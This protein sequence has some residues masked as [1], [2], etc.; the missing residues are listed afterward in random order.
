MNLLLRIAALCLAISAAAQPFWIRTGPEYL[1]TAMDSGTPVQLTLYAAPGWSIDQKIYCTGAQP[2]VA[3]NGRHRVA[4]ISGNIITLNQ[5]DG[6][7]PTPGYSGTAVGSDQFNSTT[8]AK[9]GAITEF[10]LVSGPRGVFHPRSSSTLLTRLI[11]SAQGSGTGTVRTDDP[12]GWTLLTTAL[13]S[14]VTTGCNGS[15]GC[16]K[17]AAAITQNGQNIAEGNPQMLAA[18]GWEISGDASMLGA[19][20]YYL[21]NIHKLGVVPGSWGGCDEYGA[22][23]CGTPGSAFWANDY[24]RFNGK[25]HVRAFRKIWNQLSD[26]ER[27]LFAMKFWNGMDPA[28]PKRNQMQFQSGSVS[29]NAANSVIGVGTTFTSGFVEGQGAY[30]RWP[31]QKR[32]IDD[33]TLTNVVVAASGTTSAAIINI[34]A[35]AIAISADS[36]YVKIRN[37]TGAVIDGDWP[38]SG[39]GT[40]TA[41]PITI[42]ANVTTGTYNNA[43]MTVEFWPN[44]N[45]QGQYLVVDKIT[46]DTHMSFKTNLV[47]D[48]KNAPAAVI[49]PWTPAH[50]GLLWAASHHSNGTGL[51]DNHRRVIL[52][53]VPAQNATTINVTTVSVNNLR[54]IELPYPGCL[55]AINQPECIGLND[56]NFSTGALDTTRGVGGTPQMRLTNASSALY[57]RRWPRAFNSSTSSFAVLAGDPGEN[58]NITSYA[59]MIG[60][61]LATYEDAP[62][63]TVSR[64]FEPA[65]NTWIDYVLPMNKRQWTPFSRG[66]LNLGYDGGRWKE[67]VSDGILD[68][69]DSLSPSLDLTGPFVCRA[70]EI[71]AY[72]NMPFS[73]WPDVPYI[74]PGSDAMSA[75]A[76]EGDDHKTI[77][78]TNYLCPNSAGQR[79]GNYWLTDYTTIWP[80][81]SSFPNNEMLPHRL[82]YYPSATPKENFRTNAPRFRAFDKTDIGGPGA[83]LSIF[84]GHSSFDRTKN[85]T[86]LMVTAFNEPGDHSG[87]NPP[88]SG[89]N[90]YQA[91]MAASSRVKG[92][93]LIASASK[94]TGTWNDARM[95]EGILFDPIP[96]M[97]LGATTNTTQTVTAHITQPAGA[98]GA[99]VTLSSSSSSLVP[100]WGVYIPPG[101]TS[102]TFTL[103]GYNSSAAGAAVTG[104][105]TGTSNNSTSGYATMTGNFECNPCSPATNSALTSITAPNGTVGTA[106][107]Q[108]L[109]RVTL[110]GAAPS[111]GSTVELSSDNANVVVPSSVRVRT[112]KT[113]ID[114]PISFKPSTSPI[115]GRVTATTSAGSVFVD[116]TATALSGTPANADVALIQTS[117]TSATGGYFTGSPPRPPTF[118]AIR[119]SV[120]S[121][122]LYEMTEGKGS[123][124]GTQAA[125]DQYRR[126]VLFYSPSETS[127]STVIT[128]DSLLQNTTGFHSQVQIPYFRGLGDSS[129]D[130]PIRTN[131]VPT[132]SGNTATFVKP[133]NAVMVRT[134]VLLPA[135]STKIYSTFASLKNTD[136]GAFL[137]VSNGYGTGRKET[138]IIH[139]PHAGTTDEDPAKTLLSSDSDHRV[140]FVDDVKLIWAKTIVNHIPSDSVSYVTTSAA[141]TFNIISN[142]SAGSTYA[143]T[144]NGSPLTNVVADAGGI[145]TFSTN[146]I[147]T[148][149]VVLSGSPLPLLITTPAPLPDG[150]VNQP[151]PTQAFGCSGGVP[152]YSWSLNGSYQSGLTFTA[153]EVG[154]L[155]GVPTVASTVSPEAQCS[156]SVGTNPAKKVLPLTVMAA[157]SPV[158]ITTESLPDCA[159]GA[160]YDQAL[161]AT[162]GILPLQ[163][164]LVGGSL[165]PGVQLTTNG[166]ISGVCTASGEFAPTVQ[167]ADATPPTPQTASRQLSLTVPI[168]PLTLSPVSGRI[169]TAELGTAYGYYFV[170]EGGVAP[171]MWSMSGGP[172]GLSIVDGQIIGTPTAIGDFVTTVTVADD[173]GEYVSVTVTLPV[174]T[175]SKQLGLVVTAAGQS[176]IA[177]LRAVGVDASTPCLFLIL[178]ANDQ[179]VLSGIFE[180]GP[181]SRTLGLTGLSSGLR[182]RGETSC[183]GKGGSFT[184]FSEEV[185]GA[186]SLPLKNPAYP[187]ID[188]VL[189]EYGTTPDLGT[190]VSAPCGSDCNLTIPALTR[191]QIYY[192]RRRYRDATNAVIKESSVSMTL[193]Q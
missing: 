124:I 26:D 4:S 158:N 122:Y 104:N 142:R 183:D 149:A 41:I 145:I 132:L 35:P 167:V 177:K 6:T 60:T 155:S 45:S 50:N 111:G 21:A 49:E 88:R 10:G 92:S 47:G 105:I 18:L 126:E 168:E 160:S 37:S 16:T 114:L 44:Y 110:S 112:G 93:P 175:N 23:F 57:L 20:K 53:G 67:D 1:V 116:V 13:N 15:T 48:F 40:V 140:T 68:L 165:P 169:T 89:I 100:P 119:S 184:F 22:P 39:N 188:N 17:E 163:W 174:R 147:G 178:D 65:V 51:L 115:S 107:G 159:L 192:I 84:F 3:V 94:G 150:T 135:D 185:T 166:R 8:L 113:T 81:L 79:W 130:D 36:G 25:Y 186:R 43:G 101:A 83:G 29:R 30:I 78:D 52:N 95:T 138:L 11:G 99:F 156:D 55:Q 148:V 58:L 12:S 193:I 71:Y 136:Y 31:N 121:T 14:Y 87:T 59:W 91:N 19:A 176:A 123:F 180:P 69:K 34:P 73:I 5:E 106:G 139:R 42:V 109:G 33:S 86:T 63:N 172:G 151:Y 24:M 173:S 144:I 118:R 131:N 191:G 28:S 38:I 103:F 70:P 90:L 72:F 64:F 82:V 157:S 61:A 189:I 62:P 46:D 96:A 117:T 75:Y 80:S 181:S 171:F 2:N 128:Y 187:G 146:A 27:K 164:S 125:D 108:I 74:T 85:P 162:G 7:T 66:G 129:V 32:K 127:P 120:G 143:V 190:A 77:I 98:N 179:I 141:A 97:A 134:T 170:R 137:R 56:L 54:G 182:Y 102:A 152:P 9:C 76:V 161:A 154:S 133:D 153:G